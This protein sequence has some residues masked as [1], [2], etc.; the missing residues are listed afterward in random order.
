MQ[1]ATFI[2]IQVKSC[3]ALLRVLLA[4]SRI[5]LKSVLRYKFLILATY[6]PDTVYLREQW[7]EDPWLFFEAKRGP[8]AKSLG[9]VGL[10]YGLDGP[11]AEFLWRQG[12]FLSPE[13]PDRL[14]GPPILL[15]NGYL[16]SLPRVKRPAR[17]VHLPPRLVPMFRISRAIHLLPQHRMYLIYLHKLQ[18]W[19]PPHQNMGKKSISMFE[20]KQFLRYSPTAC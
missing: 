9:N 14:W 15:Y 8:R 12:M 3:S 2:L 4:C 16:G 1:R 19:V 7:C 6:Y 11:G 5:F 18:E 10:G 17:E 20:S 13:R